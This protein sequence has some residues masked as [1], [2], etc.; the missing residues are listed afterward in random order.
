MIRG[1]TME[2]CAHVTGTD[3]RVTFDQ[4]YNRVTIQ[5]GEHLSDGDAEAVAFAAIVMTFD[6]WERLV[7][8]ARSIRGRAV[9]AGELLADIG[10]TAAGK[11]ARAEQLD[12]RHP[13]AQKWPRRAPKPELRIDGHTYR[14]V[15]GNG[16][17]ETQ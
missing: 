4:T 2:R 10:Q 13:D 7:Q 11:A 5:R 12:A 17:A 3:L 14:L 16:G 15:T 6:E 8:D 1:M 9:F